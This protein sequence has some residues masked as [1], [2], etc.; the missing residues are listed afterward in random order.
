VSSSRCRTGAG[1]GTQLL[2][3]S[4]AEAGWSVTYPEHPD[5]ER[6]VMI[7]SK[8]ATELDPVGKAMSYL[9]ARLAGVVIE[10]DE[11]LVRVLGAYVPSRDASEAKTTRKR[12]WIDAFRTALDTTASAAP[13]VL[14]GDLNVL[15]PGHTPPH[16]GQF[17]PFETGFYTSLTQ[18]PR[19]RRHFPSSTS[20]RCRAQLGQ[21][22]SPRLP[23]Q[24]CRRLL[25]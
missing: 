23:L 22:S 16:R 2:K 13:I 15:E 3:D 8:L 21:A 14:L 9:P 20:G 17:A 4:F 6:G 11:G 5:K 7:L 12:Q 25:R 10:T 24:P 18:N 1:A 19:S